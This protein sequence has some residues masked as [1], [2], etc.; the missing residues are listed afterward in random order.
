MRNKDELSLEAQAVIDRIETEYAPAHDK[1]EKSDE[2]VAWCALNHTTEDDKDVIVDIVGEA[3]ITR[4]ELLGKA[5][6]A[7]LTGFI[8]VMPDWLVIRITV[9]IFKQIV[10]TD[11]QVAR[12]ALN[13]FSMPL[14][15]H[16]FLP[17]SVKNLHTLVC[18]RLE[19][20]LN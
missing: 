8:T 15:N 16:P 19:A 17:E 12:R 5:A 2:V 10:D 14:T 20:E 6:A 18:E 1:W 3:I 7:A 11:P 4:L 13:E 9:T